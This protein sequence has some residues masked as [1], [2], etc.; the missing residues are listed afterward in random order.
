[1]IFCLDKILF[2]ISINQIKGLSRLGKTKRIPKSPDWIGGSAK[3]R[4]DSVPL[5]KLWELLNLKTPK[6][7]VLL[8][9]STLDYC[10]FLIS[11]VKG[12]YELEINKEYIKIFNLPYLSGLGTFQ[13]ETVLQIELDNL[14]T[15]KQKKIL[16]KLNKK[17]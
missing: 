6:K 4:N 1:M 5:I 7:K 12:I 8:L 11:G 14:L 9:P 13:N 16:K 3:Y 17:K 2:G 10:G 15:T